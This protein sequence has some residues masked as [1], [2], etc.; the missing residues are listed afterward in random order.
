VGILVGKFWFEGLESESRWELEL[1]LF[2][3]YGVPQGHDRFRQFIHRDRE[4]LFWC[5]R[6]ISEP[7][8][9]ALT[10]RLVVLLHINKRVIVDV[11]VEMNIRPREL[12]VAL[13][14]CQIHSYH[15]ALDTPIPTILLHQ[16]MVEEELCNMYSV[17]SVRVPED[18]TYSGVEATHV[19]I[20]T[21][22]LKRAFLYGMWRLTIRSL[23]IGIR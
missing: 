3:S 6:S 11:A 14:Q 12:S 22:T 15:N 4:T 19:P 13:F 2:T 16:W 23:R 9:C 20:S 5:K 21:R 1:R 7:W 17:E 10:V 8:S 18:A